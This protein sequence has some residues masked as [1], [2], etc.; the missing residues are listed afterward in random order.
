MYEILMWQK[1]QYEEFEHLKERLAFMVD[2]FMKLKEELFFNQ[3]EWWREFDR[4]A[5]A[6]IVVCQYVKCEP[7]I[8]VNGER[9]EIDAL[10]DEFGIGDGFEFRHISPKTVI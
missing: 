2:Q 1:V 8:V 7:H 10:R 9:Y 6:F 4:T 3:D 5:Q